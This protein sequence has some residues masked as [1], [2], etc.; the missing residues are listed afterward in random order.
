M[1]QQSQDSF[2]P[3]IFPSLSSHECPVLPETRDVKPELGSDSMTYHQSLPHSYNA[4]E[5][6]GLD[7]LA[8]SYSAL[9][10][11]PSITPNLL[12]KAGKCLFKK[13][14]VPNFVATLFIAA[15]TWKQPSAH[16]QMNGKCKVT[17]CYFVLWEVFGN[18]NPSGSTLGGLQ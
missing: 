12:S 14:Y 17:L 3:W 5:W 13:I 15:L 6:Q 10:F 1:E 11:L 18:W 4:L 9:C 7:F 8:I 16:Q 2:T